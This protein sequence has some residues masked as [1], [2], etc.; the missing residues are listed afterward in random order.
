[1]LKETLTA[2]SLSLVTA[3]S[4][5]GTA[6]APSG[7]QPVEPTP[8]PQVISYSNV[9][10]GYSFLSADLGGFEADGHGIQAGL[11]FSPVD[12]LYLAARGSWHDINVDV[13]GLGLDM[14]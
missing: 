2:L 7:K 4:F 12:H 1:M 6:P 13:L 5:A 11:E 3:A 10:L 8:P 14:R 9:S